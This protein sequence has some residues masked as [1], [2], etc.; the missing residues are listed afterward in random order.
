MFQRKVE[1]FGY[2]REE[3]EVKV[4]NNWVVVRGKQGMCEENNFRSKEF[5]KK[6]SLPAG[7]KPE[8]VTS[9]LS[10]EGILTVTRRK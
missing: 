10:P 8:D 3:I 2:K 4:E 7:M 9:S 6:F 1:A 5:T